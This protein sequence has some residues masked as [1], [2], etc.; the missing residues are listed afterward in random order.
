LDYV[1]KI[2]IM[3]AT[4]FQESGSGKTLQDAYKSLCEIAEDEYGHQEGYNGT[5]STTTGVNDVTEKY[6]KSKFDSV[7]QYIRS[8][9]EVLG[10]RDCCAICLQEPVGNKNKTKS[11]VEHIVTPGTK[12]WVL[13]YTVRHGDHFIG[14]WNTKGDAVKDARRYTENNQV[15]TTIEMEKVLDKGSNR[16]AIIKYKQSPTERGGRWVFFGWAAE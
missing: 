1:L 9:V 8:Q 5:I 11:Q 12:K 3:G 4:W 16:V 2:K 14:S 15:A 10:K 6:K 13:K 7:D